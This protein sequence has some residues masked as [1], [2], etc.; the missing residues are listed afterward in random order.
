MLSIAQ[1]HELLAR[2]RAGDERAFVDLIEAYHRP[3]CRLAAAFVKDAWR[4]EE[5][6]QETWLVVIDQLTSFEGRSSLK[7]WIFGILVNKAKKRAAREARQL[8]SELEELSELERADAHRFDAS[9][10]WSQP[11]GRWARSPEDA[12][13]VSRTL[14]LVHESI[15]ALPALQRMVMTMR[16]VQGFTAQETCEI[17]D[18]QPN[19]HRVLLH[20]GRA[21]VREALERHF[22]QGDGARR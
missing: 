5:V 8:L 6:V 21:A 2:L 10:H 4:A 17:L 7:T 20:R 14:A 19:H 11:P 12:L 9:G 18:I 13:I 16:D 1:E 15:E 3:M 22:S